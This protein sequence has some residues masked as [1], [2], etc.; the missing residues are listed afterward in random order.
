MIIKFADFEVTNSEYFENALDA[1]LAEEPFCIIAENENDLTEWNDYVDDNFSAYDDDI[2]CHFAAP[3]L[4][5]KAVGK[6]LA[7][8]ENGELM[9]LS[10]LV[11]RYLNMAN[12]YKKFVAEHP[13]D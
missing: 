7:Y 13:I 5:M 4:K 6:W 1:I 10:D 3:A 2:Y 11:N 12:F 8:N 9:E